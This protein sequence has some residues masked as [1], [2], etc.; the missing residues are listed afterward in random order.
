MYRPRPWFVL[1]APLAVAVGCF[2]C[3]GSIAG[4]G[5]PSGDGTPGAPGEGNGQGGPTGGG[6]P[7]GAG[8]S[9]TGNGPGATNPGATPGSGTPVVDIGALCKTTS[10]GPSPL[11]RLTRAE[12]NNTVRDLLGVTDGPANGFVPDSPVLG[13]DNSAEGQTAQPL[14]VE[15]YDDAAARIAATAVVDL[16]KLMKCAPATTVGGEDACAKKFMV[17][18][19]KRAFRRPISD[20]ES[21]RFTSFY[22]AAKPKY[23][24]AGAI[25]MY[26]T[27]ILQSSSFLY[28]T[29]F[30]TPD[31]AAPQIAKLSPH[32]LA[33]RL[34]YLVFNS[35]PDDALTAAADAGKLS[36]PAEIA[37]QAER[38]LGDP[39]AKPAM[40]HFFGQWLTLDE[41]DQV[42]KDS[43]IYPAWNLTIKGLLRKETETFVDAVFFG[44][45]PKLDGLLTA[46]YTYTNKQ[47][48]TFYGLTGPQGT[49]FEKTPLPVDKRIGVLTQ[50]SLMS[51]LAKENQ[52][53]PIER[54]KFTREHLL[55]Q[56]LPQPPPNLEVK[57]PAIKPGQTT[58]E[59]FRVHTTDPTC[60]ACHRMMD[61]VGFGF[62]NL[63]GIGKWRDMDQNL[64]V[65]A[66][67]E[68]TNTGEAALDGTFKGAAALVK[69]LAPSTTVR[70]CVV[71]QWF[72][73]GHGRSDTDADAC[74]MR[75]LQDQFASTGS[76]FKKLVIA[77]TQTH[78]F[79]YK[80]VEPSTGG[81]P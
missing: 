73:F 24:F 42:N 44:A 69:K 46:D 81:A 66:S 59:R 9:P 57:P 50:G 27:A 47:L 61:P 29:E 20:T 49:A 10:P 48:A 78:A 41:M 68:L 36:T 79:L 67:G 2:A 7:G 62:E 32:E 14:L 72:R 65:D 5:P 43:V 13:F 52:S 11:R 21:T 4:S 55:C 53:S 64:P 30:G 15:Q 70:S 63:D 60:G 33:A 23:G 18:F 56:A 26:L 35:M 45:T 37:A 39:K 1:A 28:R 3:S 6:G 74:T 71:K 58:R 76:D 12:Y 54:G 16:P 25:E 8:T 17:D 34:S 75:V 38:L 80:S 40:Q 31:K 22:G 77:M 51:I 19:A